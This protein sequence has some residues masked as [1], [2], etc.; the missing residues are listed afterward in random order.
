MLLRSTGKLMMTELFT[1]SFFMIMSDCSPNRAAGHWYVQLQGKAETDL[2][3]MLENFD[4]VWNGK[5]VRLF[6]IGLT[7]FCLLMVARGITF[8]LKDSR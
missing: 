7:A 8:R 6:Q 1:L 2:T 4:N 3:V 5:K